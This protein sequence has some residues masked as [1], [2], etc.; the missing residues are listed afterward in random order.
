MLLMVTAALMAAGLYSSSAAAQTISSNDA[1][2]SAL[3][4]SEKDII[5]FDGGRTSYEVGVDSTVTQVTVLSTRQSRCRDAG[6]RPR[7]TPT[8]SP[9]A[10]RW[11]FRRG[12]TR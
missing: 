11:T 9:R 5:G 1:T 2:L 12:E 4:V 3:S 6:L 10:T 8:L 7:R